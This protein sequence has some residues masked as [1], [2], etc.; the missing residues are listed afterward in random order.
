MVD[1]TKVS[2]NEEVIELLKMRDDIEKKILSLDEM[3]LVK[4]EILALEN[5]E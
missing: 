5:E 2:E 3:A 1:Y 4:Y